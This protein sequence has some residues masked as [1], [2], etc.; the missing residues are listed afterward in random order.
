M[1]FSMHANIRF[2]EFPGQ[3]PMQLTSQ[4]LFGDFEYRGG[5]GAKTAIEAQAIDRAMLQ[6]G[7]RITRNITST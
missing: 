3:P 7:V 4:R 1:M 5:T 2:F 6:Y